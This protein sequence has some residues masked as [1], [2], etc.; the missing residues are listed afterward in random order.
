MNMSRLW[1]RLLVTSALASVLVPAGVGGVHGG[2]T[3]LPGQD[4]CYRGQNGTAGLTIGTEVGRSRKWTQTYSASFRTSQIDAT[5]ND[6]GS[7]PASCSDAIYTFNLVIPDPSA[8]WSVQST[9]TPYVGATVTRSGGAT[10]VTI[11]L[12]GDGATSTLSVVGTISTRAAKAPASIRDFMEIERTTPAAPVVTDRGP[13]P[14]LFAPGN[15]AVPVPVP[16]LYDYVAGTPLED[17]V[18]ATFGPSTHEVDAN[19]CGCAGGY[20]YFS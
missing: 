9:S 7:S 15:T 18:A 13:S 19:A 16:G 17:Q 8:Q 11:A 5:F 1:R 14:Q 12:R 10:F 4:G 6:T 2:A 20:G 3:G